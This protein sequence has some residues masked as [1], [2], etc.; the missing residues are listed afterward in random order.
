MT[1]GIWK[2][3]SHIK[4]STF[5]VKSGNRNLWYLLKEVLK[6]WITFYISF[7]FCFCVSAN[8]GRKSIYRTVHK[9]AAKLHKQ[10]SRYWENFDKFQHLQL[11][12]SYVHQMWIAGTSLQKLVMWSL[13][14]GH[15]TFKRSSYLQL[16][17]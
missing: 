5:W 2:M 11:C 14:H 17:T 15:G 9:N 12:I 1:K 16:W 7:R 10:L 8:V 4:N 13:Q 6:K 3:N